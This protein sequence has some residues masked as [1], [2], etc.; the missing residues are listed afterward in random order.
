MLTGGTDTMLTW[1]D[2]WGTEPPD[3]AEATKELL[4]ALRQAHKLN[5][6]EKPHETTSNEEE[7]K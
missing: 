4:L 1:K 3:L 7:Q 5:P 2:V 6:Q